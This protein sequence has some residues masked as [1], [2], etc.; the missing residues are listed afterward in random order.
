MS[1]TTVSIGQALAPDGTPIGAVEWAVRLIDGR[2]NLVS[3]VRTVEAPPVFG[4]QSGTFAATDTAPAVQLVPI[5][6]LSVPAAAVAPIRWELSLRQVGA[7]EVHRWILAVPISDAALNLLDLAAATAAPA[8][9]SVA[10][11]ARIA[12]LEAN[13]L[14]DPANLPDGTMLQIVERKWVYTS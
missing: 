6:E 9:P 11:L 8:E 4:V 14:P 10:L 3:A 12:A 2:G 7:V 1:L 5:E 13:Q